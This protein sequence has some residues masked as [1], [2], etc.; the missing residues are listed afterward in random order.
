MFGFHTGT[1]LQLVVSS[2]SSQRK[3]QKLGATKSRKRATLS[4]KC[5]IC[6]S[7]GAN[8][9]GLAAVGSFG[10]IVLEQLLIGAHSGAAQKKGHSVGSNA[11]LQPL[12]SPRPHYLTVK[13]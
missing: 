2:R 7:Q 3:T 9:D 6:V 11:N 10:A 4:T 8:N 1:G 12:H 5:L 13:I